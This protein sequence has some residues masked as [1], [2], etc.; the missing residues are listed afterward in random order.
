MHN[1]RN[2]AQILGEKA[3]VTNMNFLGD[4][5]LSIM[6]K[7]L[8]GLWARQEVISDNLANFETPNYKRKTVDFETYLQNAINT[9]EKNDKKYTDIEES[10][11]EFDRDEETVR[12]DGN[13]VDL[14]QEQLLMIK[15]NYQYMYTQRVLNDYFTRLST[16]INEGK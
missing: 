12:L 4:A 11:I 5:Y 14:E 9:T 6:N 1:I 10:F 3:G 16:A 2:Y 13:S 7:T 8:D 15:N